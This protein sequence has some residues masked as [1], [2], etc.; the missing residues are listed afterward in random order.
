MYNFLVTR[1]WHSSVTTD[2]RLFEICQMFQIA[3]RGCK[4]PHQ[5]SFFHILKLPKP[6][7]ADVYFRAFVQT[8]GTHTWESQ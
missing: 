5:E 8:N 3:I 6:K 2:Q 1:K 4:I 7:N